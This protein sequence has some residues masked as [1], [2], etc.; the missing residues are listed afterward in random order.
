MSVAA[1]LSGHEGEGGTTD[2]EAGGAEG[3][4]AGGEGAAG[5]ENVVDEQKV[6]DALRMQGGGAP[7]TCITTSPG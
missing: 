4:G 1:L 5:G 6:A 3:G 7:P 2:A